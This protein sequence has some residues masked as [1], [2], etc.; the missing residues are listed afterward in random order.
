MLNIM[1]SFKFDFLKNEFFPMYRGMLELK[2]LL[3]PCAKMA[4]SQ[5]RPVAA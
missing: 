5:I 1:Q 4:C 2:M 3:A